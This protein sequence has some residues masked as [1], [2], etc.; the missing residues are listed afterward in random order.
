MNQNTG[1]RALASLALV[2]SLLSS[3]AEAQTTAVIRGVV[4]DTFSGVLPGATVRLENSLTGFARTTLTGGEGT[5]VIPNVPLGLYQLVVDMPGFASLSRPVACHSSVPVELAISLDVASQSDTVTVVPEQA[6]LDT[7]SA[8]TR[9]Q[10]SQA[11]I[12]QL[13]AA[14]GS[15]GLEAVLVTFPGFAQNANGAI[16]PRGAHNQM[17]FVVDGLTISD[18]LT[19][20]FA[21]ALD[22]SIV[23]TVELMT[24]NIPAEFGQKVS[25]VAVITSRSGL[26]TARRLTGDVLLAGA[27]FSTWHGA[28]QAGGTHGPLGYFGSVTTM[29]TERFLDQVSRDNLHNGGAFGRG[30]GRLDLHPRPSD[31]FRLHVMGGTSSFEVANLR[32]QQQAGQDQ[33]QRLADLAIWGAYLRTLDASSTLESV[34][35]YRAAAA[36]LRPSPGDTPVTAVQDR[37]LSTWTASVRYSRDAGRTTLRAGGDLQRV[38]VHEA[39]AMAL[40]DPRFNDPAGDHFNAALLPFDLSRGGTWFRFEQQARGTLAS[41]FLQ[42]V[43]RARS[44]T[45]STGLRYDDYRFLVRGRQLQPR[46]GVS[47]TL[48]GAAGVVRASYNRNYQTP[49]NE[50]LLLSNSAAAAALAPAS[51]R[52]ALGDAHQP[53]RPER[54]DVFEVGYQLALS[55]WGS[56][57]LSAYHKTS[58]DQQDNN[59]FFDTGII[60][61]TTLAAI[62]VDGFESRLI[63]NPTLGVSGTLSATAGRAISTPPFTG[64][65][66][67]GQDAVD[68]LSSG[69]FRIDHDQRLAL[70]GTMH[71]APGGGWWSSASVR[72]DSGLVANPS[73]PAVVAQDPDFADLLPYVDLEADVPRVKPRTIVDLASGWNW[74]AEGRRAWS[75][76]VQVAN[77]TNRT[78]LYN[79]Q[80]VFVGTRLVQPRTWSVRLKRY[81]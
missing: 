34:V 52:Q 66:F 59:N 54:Q 81:F 51:V 29:R 21:N 48:P 7:D 19:G 36:E 40:T 69:P 68:L 39:F 50:N 55:H 78:A 12:E 75:V 79:F 2:A 25:G 74:T 11:R 44:A 47:W 1:R 17:T 8:G 5:F 13:P 26:G 38:P 60:F 53:I 27:G 14:V 72:Y 43:V 56:V 3:N 62:R 46:V 31:L 45:I 58:R 76:Q 18:Q 73:D 33:Q 49:P 15:R 61:P 22:A 77:V 24:G 9:N 30:F 6:L 37:R 28:G 4:T 32:S 80:S 41:A 70:H 10:L 71:Y 23:Q 20:A 65:L 63:L 64:G 42:G 57:D 16:H 35:G 67:L